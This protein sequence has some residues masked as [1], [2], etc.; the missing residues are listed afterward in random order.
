[1]TLMTL[2]SDNEHDH[3]VIDFTQRRE[4]DSQWSYGH[5]VMVETQFKDIAILMDSRMIHFTLIR[6]HPL[7][8]TS[9]LGISCKV[10]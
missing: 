5:I 3:K 7:P 6:G 2:R 10:R 9:L 1:M 8:S 4:L